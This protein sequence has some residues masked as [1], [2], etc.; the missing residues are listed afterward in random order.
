LFVFVLV[1]VVCGSIRKYGKILSTFRMRRK[2]LS[3]C[4]Y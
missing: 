4:V 2:L 3:L 1:F